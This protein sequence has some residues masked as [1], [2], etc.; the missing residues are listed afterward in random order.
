MKELV[1]HVRLQNIVFVIENL[2]LIRVQ[3][4]IGFK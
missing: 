1:Q 4:T 3:R 2:K